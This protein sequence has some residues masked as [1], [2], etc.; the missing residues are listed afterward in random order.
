MLIYGG[1]SDAL[2]L[3]V[4]VDKHVPPYE[5]ESE[6]GGSQAFAGV[7]VPVLA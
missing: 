3:V 7:Q 2:G 1:L 5:V 4:L 6:I